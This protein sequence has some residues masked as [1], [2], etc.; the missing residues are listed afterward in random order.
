MKMKHCQLAAIRSNPFGNTKL[1][2]TIC[3]AGESIEDND[4]ELTKPL[5]SDGTW[6]IVC[7]WAF[8]TVKS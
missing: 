5:F 7:R 3:E 6:T 2:K 8:C 1:Q 4:P